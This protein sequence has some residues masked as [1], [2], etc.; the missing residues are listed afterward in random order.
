MAATNDPDD[1]RSRAP[2]TSSRLPWH[3]AWE[4]KETYSEEEQAA[5]AAASHQPQETRGAPARWAQRFRRLSR[6]V[7]IDLR[8]GPFLGGTVSTRYRH[9][10]A[11]PVG[12]SDYLVLRAIFEGRV[13]DGDLLVDVGCGRGRVLNHWLGLR[14]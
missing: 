12:N 5:W 2:S 14:K 3:R 13:Q 7:V 8:Y 1:G 6:N 10:G 4:P 11:H 9:E